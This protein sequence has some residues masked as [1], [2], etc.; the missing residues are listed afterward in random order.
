M[1]PEGRTRQGAE[2]STAGRLSTE[3][4]LP[5]G[6]LAKIATTVLFPADQ[7]QGAKPEGC[8]QAQEIWFQAGWRKHSI[9]LIFLLSEA[10]C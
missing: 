1:D 8:S 7:G 10:G 6:P 5:G 3:V 4:S 9:S 2:I